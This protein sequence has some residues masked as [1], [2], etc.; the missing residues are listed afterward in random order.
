MTG[1][2]GKAKGVARRIG[3][4][5]WLALAGVIIGLDQLTKWLAEQYLV[6]G[7]PVPVLPL[8]NLTLAYN[9]GAAFSLLA[10]A[11][12]WQRWLFAG[13]ALVV[14]VLIIGWLRRLG[15]EERLTGLA[16]TLI[17]G[18]ALGNLIDR[19]Y[20]G[21]VIDFIDVYYGSYHWPAFNIADSAITVGATL[22]VI[23]SLFGGPRRSS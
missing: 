23:S 12:G 17:L 11:G 7:E 6:Y 16:L 1:M 8:F 21:Y 10:E 22:L 13:L 19:L 15:P 2:T 14:S 3:L 9:T 20:L 4:S 5:R 18:G